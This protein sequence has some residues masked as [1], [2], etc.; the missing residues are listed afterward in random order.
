MRT[1]VRMENHPGFDDALRL[2][3]AALAV[4]AV[5]ASPVSA[6]SL[7]NPGEK[8]FDADTL[9]T[10]E[11]AVAENRFA[12]LGAGDGKAHAVS[13]GG[14]AVTI[15][16]GGNEDAAH[17]A[18]IFVNKPNTSLRLNG[19]WDVQLEQNAKAAEE[20]GPVYLGI[21]VVDGSLD[22]DGTVKVRVKTD[23]IVAGGLSVNEGKAV[24]KGDLADIGVVGGSKYVVGVENARGT[25]TLDSSEIRINASSDLR[26]DGFYSDGGART[27]FNG[28]TSIKAVGGQY[29]NGV[30]PHYSTVTFADDTHVEAEGG[31]ETWV[32]RPLSDE[33][34]T[35]AVVNFNGG[36]T[37]IKG[38]SPKSVLGVA[39][40]GGNGTAVNF[41]GKT[42]SVT[43]TAETG[44]AKALQAQY[45]SAINM[46]A[47]AVITATGR[48]AHGMS[49]NGYGKEAANLDGTINVNGSMS[50]TVK[51]D[52]AYGASVVSHADAT[53]DNDGIFL[54]G[55]TTM[56]VASEAENGTAVGL[57]IDN[58]N[59]GKARIVVNDADVK[60][61]GPNAFGIQAENKGDVTVTGDVRAAATGANAVGAS[62]RNSTLALSEGASAEVTGEKTGIVMDAGSKLNAEKASVTTNT[63]ESAGATTLTN[64]AVLGVTG[65]EGTASTLGRV[66]AA[67]STVELGS[68]KFTIDEFTGADKTLLLNDVAADVKIENRA[69]DPDGMTLA[70]SGKANDAFTSSQETVD[71]LLDKKLSRDG[72]TIEVREGLVNDAVTGTV[73]VD[74]AGNLTLTDVVVEKNSTVDAFGSVASL[75]AYQWRHE[76]NDLTKRMGELRMSPEGVGSWARIYGSTFEYGAQNLTA[77]NNSVQVGVDATAGAGWTVGAAFSY[78]DGSTTYDRGEADNEAYALGVYG[79]WMHESG[80]FVDLIAKYGRLSNDFTLAGLEGSFDSNALSVS[81]E[82]GWHLKL[83][84]VAFVEPQAEVSYGRIMGDDF[85]ASRGDRSVRFSQEDTEFLIT[86]L[87]VRTGFYFPKDR[88]TVYARASVAHDFKGEVEATAAS[89]AGRNTAFADL[90]GTW[91]EW[92]LGASFNLTDRTFAYVDLERTTGAEAD[93]KV[94]YSVGVRHVW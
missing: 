17:Y 20:T 5:F 66:S 88:G 77:K 8:T 34:E 31:V 30:R 32:V 7:I 69:T 64:G 55:S 61:S 16:G 90:G 80:R 21:R 87:G 82:Y 75:T 58:S 23:S 89:G 71:A 65:G 91:L 3:M 42:A 27:V 41:N 46:N 44:L 73:T 54:N 28:A 9:L 92:G 47:D 62:L 50:V 11:G 84:D 29:G 37:V 15:T 78:T 52:L 67:G 57:Y 93:E 48:E 43:V 12:G 81:A 38:T 51:G 74:E 72:E 70:A 60:A 33:G 40:S 86:R 24:I 83:S 26:A 79:T 53:D 14:H 2:S 36:N 35:S 68:G 6:A 10:V 13:T 18:G 22:V 56:N 4:A 59:I 25:L 76:M 63:M 94:R 19:G 39:P 45:G 1:F 85:T 49:I